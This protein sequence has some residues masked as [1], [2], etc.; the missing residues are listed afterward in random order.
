MTTLGIVAACLLVAVLATFVLA[1]YGA[2]QIMRL[3]LLPLGLIALTGVAAGL[4]LGSSSQVIASPQRIKVAAPPERGCCHIGEQRV[5]GTTEEFCFTVLGGDAW[6]V[7]ECDTGAPLGCCL[8]RNKQLWHWVS[9]KECYVW[10]DGVFWA[11]GSCP[12]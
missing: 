8:D 11:E 12:K 5:G 7:G 10:L 4:L 2:R 3:G 9:E 6:H 1:L